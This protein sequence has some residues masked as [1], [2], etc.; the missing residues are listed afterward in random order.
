MKWA[1]RLSRKGY[2]TSL[3]WSFQAL[4]SHEKKTPRTAENYARE[5]R[6]FK[7]SQAGCTGHCQYVDGLHRSGCYSL[8]YGRMIA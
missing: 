5:S 8:T 6:I 4:S 7:A 1:V 3:S 2:V